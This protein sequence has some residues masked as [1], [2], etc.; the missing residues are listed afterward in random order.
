M[1]KNQKSHKIH[2]I[3]KSPKFANFC[4]IPTPNVAIQQ[5]SQSESNKTHPETGNSTPENN[6]PHNPK[7]TKCTH[8]K[9]QASQIKPKH[10]T[11]TKSCNKVN[12]NRQNTIKKHKPIKQRYSIRN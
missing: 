3:Q 10:K 6:N 11:A 8:R 7:T 9:Q 2:K 4:L 1:P 12:H 5:I